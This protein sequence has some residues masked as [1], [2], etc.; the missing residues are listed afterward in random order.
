MTTYSRLVSSAW[1][2]CIFQR[3]N[4]A[5]LLLVC[6][7]HAATQIWCDVKIALK[8]RTTIIYNNNISHYISSSFLHRCAVYAVNTNTHMYIIYI[9]ILTRLFLVWYKVHTYTYK[10]CDKARWR[11]WR[12]RGVECVWTRCDAMTS[13]ATLTIKSICVSAAFVNRSRTIAIKIK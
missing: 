13:A 3:A 8:A 5:R 11:W 2:K 4:N 12:Q 1:I 7:T 6:A 9:Y 10:A